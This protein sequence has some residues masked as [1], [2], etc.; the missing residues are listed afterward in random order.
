MSLQG[1]SIVKSS[2]KSTEDYLELEFRNDPSYR[3]AELN[4]KNGQTIDVRIIE[5]KADLFRKYFLFRPSYKIIN[6]SYLRIEEGVFIIE[7]HFLKDL[8]PKA[9]ALMCNLSIMV[10][11]Q[12]HP[13]PAYGN[14]TTYGTKGL[15]DNGYFKEQDAKLKIV[16]QANDETERY[17]EGMRLLIRVRSGHMTKNNE[18]VAYKIMKK[19]FVVLDGIY[20]L[21]TALT[22][23]SPLDDLENGIA[24]NERFENDKPS[25]EYQI[26]GVDKIKVGRT[27]CYELNPKRIDVVYEIDDISYAEITEQANGICKIKALKSQGIIT[28]SARCGT[29]I[30][31]EKDLILY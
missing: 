13:I 27:E 14:N 12:T 21:E 10:K 5:D 18:F 8:Y 19:D 9:E 1:G 16:I 17:Y 7:N 24:Y 23:L 6:G 31:D 25:E 2:I 26:M 22:S 15:K 4:L 30:L 20:I 28:L 11:G 3:L 29:E